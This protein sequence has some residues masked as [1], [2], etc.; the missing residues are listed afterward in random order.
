MIL[1]SDH[2]IAAAVVWYPGKI[3][4]TLKGEG[5]T[6]GSSEGS[7]KEEH[8]FE[9]HA[10]A[11]FRQIILLSVAHFLILLMFNNCNT[12]F[13]SEVLMVMNE[14]FNIVPC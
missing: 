14:N 4:I 6:T 3:T 11:H 12:S 2:K 7:V 8:S 5:C 1:K 9:K 10:F 13:C